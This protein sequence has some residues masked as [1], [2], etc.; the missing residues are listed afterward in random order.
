M[1]DVYLKYKMAMVA[2]AWIGLFV[3]FLAAVIYYACHYRK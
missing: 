3:A 1:I 2:V